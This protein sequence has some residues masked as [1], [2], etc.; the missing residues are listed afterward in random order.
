MIVALGFTY[1]YNT[2]SY[3]NNSVI[4]IKPQDFNYSLSGIVTV[5][6]VVTCVTDS[7]SCCSNYNE[8]SSW[9]Y[10][11]GRQV[12]EGPNLQNQ[13]CHL[14]QQAID[15]YNTVVLSPVH[16]RSLTAMENC[17]GLY[18]CL[19]RDHHGQLQQLFLGIHYNVTCK[20]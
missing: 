1:M 11:S 6:P 15:I 3:G 9:Y 14:Q 20:H 18:Q 16:G 12:S 8:S 2:K 19:I 5:M 17:S 13:G 4:L 10:P 7:L